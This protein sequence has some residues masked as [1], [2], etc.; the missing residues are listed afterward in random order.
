MALGALFGLNPGP[1][2]LARWCRQAE[3]EFVGVPC[4]ILDQG[5]SAFGQAGR[6]VLIDCRSGNV[7]HC[8]HAGD[9]ALLIFNTGAKHA[10]LDSLYAARRRECEDAFEDFAALLSQRG[11]VWRI[12]PPRKSKASRRN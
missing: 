2:A 5:V 6:L 7:Y 11:A 9:R 3:N 12:C 4:G 8:A 1:H 10:L